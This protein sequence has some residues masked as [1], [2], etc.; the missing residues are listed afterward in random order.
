MVWIRNRS[1]FKVRN[2]NIYSFCSTTLLFGNV[3]HQITVTMLRYL[4]AATELQIQSSNLPY[5]TF[6][7]N[8][9][10]LNLTLKA[11]L[12]SSVATT[13]L[14]RGIAQS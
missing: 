14:T 2:R 4:V 6:V 1:F 12:G 11:T 10:E 3:F 5:V 9:L 7:L 8:H 13:P